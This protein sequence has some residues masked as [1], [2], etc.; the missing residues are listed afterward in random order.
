L[1]DPRVA[2]SGKHLTRQP[3]MRCFQFYGGASKSPA[4]AGLPEY[5]IDVSIIYF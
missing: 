4:E 3:G 2:Q 5:V 1:R